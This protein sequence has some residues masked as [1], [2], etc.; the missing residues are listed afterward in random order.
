[1]KAFVLFL[2]VLCL[3]SSI[4]YADEK[5]CGWLKKPTP[6]NVFLADRDGDWILEAQG[7]YEI[8]EA[9]FPSWPD[10]TEKSWVA[11]GPTGYGYGCVCMNVETE[12]STMHVLKISHI[13]V[14]PLKTCR[15]DKYLKNKEP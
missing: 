8:P 10:F 1:M 14:L 9:Q 11:Y 3:C 4:S 2:L 12:A 6:G 5:R 7:G 13:K 15:D